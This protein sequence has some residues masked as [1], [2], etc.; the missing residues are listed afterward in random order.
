MPL[1]SELTY[2]EDDCILL[3]KMI[4]ENNFEQF[5]II[6]NNKFIYNNNPIISYQ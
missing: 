5:K 3:K 1:I 2:S 6:L 4:D